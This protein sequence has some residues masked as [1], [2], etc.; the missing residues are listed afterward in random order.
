MSNEEFEKRMEFIL[1]HQ[2]QSAAKLGQLEDIVARLAN[3]SL[4]RLEDTD[5]KIAALVD[6]QIRLTDSQTFIGEHLRNTDEKIEALVDSQIRLTDFTGEHLRNTDEQI[7]A[8]VESQTLNGEHL[9]NTDEQ[10]AALVDSQMRLTESQARTDEEARRTDE[11]LRSL[12]A[13][14]DRYF[15]REGRNGES[16]G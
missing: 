9:R 10:I 13:L 11:K 2:A 1:E 12:I 14:L 8:L 5:E 3:A 6:S 7:A 15:S 16:Q 4:K